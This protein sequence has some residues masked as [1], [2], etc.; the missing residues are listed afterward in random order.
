MNQGK[1]VICAM[2]SVGL[3]MAIFAWWA[4][5][6]A[7]Q[8]VLATL[9]PEVA[10]TVRNGEKVEL[11]T[12][13]AEPDSPRSAP[14]GE[15]RLNSGEILNYIVGQRDITDAPGLIHARHHLLHERGYDWDEVSTPQPSDLLQQPSAWTVG[16]RFTHDSVTATWLF[17]FEL[18][19]A[20]VLEQNT[21]I[22]IAPIAPSLQT[23]IGKLPPILDSASSGK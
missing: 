22:G 3:G 13:T 5:Y 21:M 4:R 11:L 15:V 8:R 17:D 12:L 6:S 2:V 9:G 7:S 10:V 18:R 14:P 23:F 16:L 20:Y 19:R 1:Y